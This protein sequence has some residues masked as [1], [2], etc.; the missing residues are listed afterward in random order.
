MNPKDLMV[1][2]KTVDALRRD[3]PL[4]TEALNIPG[5]VRQELHW[6][7][8]VQAVRDILKRYD[9]RHEE[10]ALRELH[11][12]VED[13]FRTLQTQYI[14]EHGEQVKP[15]R[16]HDEFER[17]FAEVRDSKGAI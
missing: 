4:R 11:A 7:A 10:E 6:K 3:P 16:D 5:Q 9:P 13:H 2:A 14:I 8:Q 1:Q 15:W 17:A 12:L